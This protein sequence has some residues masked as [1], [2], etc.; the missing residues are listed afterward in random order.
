MSKRPI[1]RYKEEQLSEAMA[2]IRN[3][4]KI[5][6][7]SRVFGVPRGTLQDRL[8][9]RVPEVPRKMGPNSVLT[10]EEETALKDWCIALAKC[11]FPLKCED[12]LNTVHNI[13]SEE[14][15]PNPFVNN[16]PGTSHSLNE[17]QS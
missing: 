5:R 6:E 4:M 9:L 16:R 13:I 7:A 3:G 12:L 1:H 17:I 8:H 2:A 11:G 10:K 15:R 14:N